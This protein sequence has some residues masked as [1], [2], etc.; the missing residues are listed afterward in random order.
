MSLVLGDINAAVLN[1]LADK[2]RGVADGLGPEGLTLVN[3]AIDHLQT[4]GTALES[5]TV[6][7]VFAGVKT[8]EDPLLARVDR[9]AAVLEKFEGFSNGFDI[10]I[11]PKP[12]K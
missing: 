11:V 5:K 12:N 10:S 2:L 9:I 1:G 4:I 6:A 7:D 3:T 8:V